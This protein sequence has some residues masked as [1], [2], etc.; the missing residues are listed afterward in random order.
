MLYELKSKQPVVETVAIALVVAAGTV[1]IIVGR[2]AV[3][4]RADNI[5]HW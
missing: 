2:T 5:N 3:V 4:A 1:V